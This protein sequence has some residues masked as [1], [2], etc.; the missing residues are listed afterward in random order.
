MRYRQRNAS[1][2]SRILG[3]SRYRWGR[4]STSPGIPFVTSTFRPTLLSRSFTFWR[5][6]RPRRSPSSVMRARLASRCSWRVRPRP[7]EPSCKA[8]ITCNTGPRGCSLAAGAGAN[9]TAIAT[10]GAGAVG[11]PTKA[12]HELAAV[13]PKT[14]AANVSVLTISIRCV[15]LQT[16][17]SCPGLPGTISGGRA[18]ALAACETSS[19]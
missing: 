19:C 11:C 18:P 10:M 17:L 9:G 1:D 7:T 15:R 12:C 5:T 2:Y 4:S 16:K 3:V 8:A 6:A 13:I 14:S